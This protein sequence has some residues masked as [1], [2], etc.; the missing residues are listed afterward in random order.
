MVLAW[1]FYWGMDYWPLCII[2]FS[3]STEVL[4]LPPHYAKIIYG[5]IMTS[6]VK[7][8]IYWGGCFYMFFKPLSKCSWGLSN[9]LL[10]TFHPVT[11]VSIYD[12]TFLLDGILIFWSHQEVIYSVASFKVDLHSIFIACFLYALT[13]SFI[14]RN[15]HIWFL[16][17]VVVTRVIVASAIL[18]DCGFVFDLDPVEHPCRIFT[19]CECLL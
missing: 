3:Y 11:F 6:F 19:S 5:D 17:V 2:F 18:I 7:M 16:V 14:I 4:V 9:V 1:C 15:H 8:V 10:I 12:S 13:D